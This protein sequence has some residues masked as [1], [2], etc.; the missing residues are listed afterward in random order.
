MNPV[1]ARRLAAQRLTG[2]PF[3][4]PEEAVRALAAV[5]AQDYPG[6]RWALGLRTGAG[7]AE[8]DR[9]YDE[10]RLLR[11]HVLRPTWHVL[12]PEDLLG[13]L[14]LTGPR[15]LRGL[16]SR[17]RNLALD[18]RTIARACDLIEEALS[19]RPGLSRAELAEVLGAAGIDP[20]GQRL[21]HLLLVAELEARVTSG[22]RQGKQLTWARLAERV[23]AAAE[24]DPDA[25]LEGLA[26]RYFSARGPARLRDFGWW[27]GLPLG[28]ARR[29]VAMAGDRLR[30]EEIGGEEHWSAAEPP[31]AGGEPRAHLLPNFDEYLVA[32]QDR[33]AALHPAGAPDPADLA[34]GSIL[35]NV[36]LV[37]G[38]VRGAWRRVGSGPR[39][40]IEL[41]LMPGLDPGEL[42]AAEE[43]TERTRA[44]LAAAG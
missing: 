35:S 32:Y 9:L 41:K 42:R 5:Q 39:L 13:L 33:S 17:H 8:V 28:E 2:A 38:L 21:P 15:I 11:T 6:S 1:A 26:A 14:R 43:A 18:A 29:G 25:V 19:G 4:G 27:S 37:D 10:G 31:A 16:G 7:P 40:A 34:F 22:P 23:P 3:A 24:P 30:R 36:V 44:F 12:V 20:A